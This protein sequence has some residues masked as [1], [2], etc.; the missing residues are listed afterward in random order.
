MPIQSKHIK[1]QP[2]GE[3][4]IEQT[5]CT[6]IQDH[7]KDTLRHDFKIKRVDFLSKLSTKKLSFRIGI[8][9]QGSMDQINQNLIRFSSIMN[10]DEKNITTITNEET[11]ITEIH[12]YDANTIIGFFNTLNYESLLNDEHICLSHNVDVLQL[13]ISHTLFWLIKKIKVSRNDPE[14][15]EFDQIGNLS[16]VV[17]SPNEQRY[18]L[19]NTAEVCGFFKKYCHFELPSHFIAL[20]RSQLKINASRYANA[21]TKANAQGIPIVFAQNQF[22]QAA[23]SNDSS[24]ISFALDQR[25]HHELH[26]F[27]AHL[28]QKLGSDFSTQWRQKENDAYLVLSCI[29]AQPFTPE[30]ILLLIDVLTQNQLLPQTQIQALHELLT[31]KKGMPEPTIPESIE[32][33][34][35]CKIMYSLPTG[36]PLITPHGNSYDTQAI[37]MHLN[38]KP[39]DPCDPS[40]PL[41]ANLLRE[42]L[43]V[44]R[45]IE[46][47]RNPSNNNDHT[48]QAP[49]LLIN[50]AT[51]TFYKNPEV[52][53]NGETV[54][55]DN[56]FYSY[57]QDYSNRCVAELISYYQT[58]LT[59]RD[60]PII[61]A[62]I[63]A[64]IGANLGLLC[65]GTGALSMEAVQNESEIFLP[66]VEYQALTETMTIH[67]ASE[68]Y[69]RRFELGIKQWCHES[70][71]TPVFS[72]D[73]VTLN[74]L[75]SQKVVW[76]INEQSKD[77][78]FHA[79]VE[80]RNDS[81]I[82][83]VLEHLCKLP[84]T[85]FFDALKEL[86]GSEQIDI[87]NGIIHSTQL[88]G[89]S[90][91]PRDYDDE[92]SYSSQTSINHNI[93]EV[94]SKADQSRMYSSE[95]HTDMFDDE[96]DNEET[97]CLPELDSWAY[98]SVPAADQQLL[99][100]GRSGNSFF[101]PHLRS[102]PNPSFLPMDTIYE[103]DGL[104][105]LN[106]ENHPG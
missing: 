56:N 29:N 103:E 87:L 43:L 55:G 45:L 71:S 65:S 81:K 83:M 47:Y 36:A 85:V 73:E 28:K 7:I 104:N 63:R 30:N 72:P 92:P 46:F 10:I 93:L 6:A 75:Q 97:F 19:K 105:S 20:I 67:F 33:I 99:P 70:S 49:I 57:T 69:A 52:L 38:N 14:R 1:H 80:I 25:E 60:E 23:V 54:D 5:L 35:E 31:I 102:Q 68:E 44:K 48:A 64:T 59:P 53:A 26:L 100:L 2:S 95:V 50:P 89:W 3:I 27:Q 74:R 40:Y 39:T 17:V 91:R 16:A 66:Y 41:N 13:L 15:V 96:P 32:R 22:K 37:L 77:M 106:Q 98:R 76:D 84:P 34:L 82:S 11:K 90:K 101:Q 94:R 8:A 24:K 88:N 86:S 9:H 58:I 78:T 51:Q 4:N 21:L 18:H 42:N 79:N 61:R 62:G 12:I